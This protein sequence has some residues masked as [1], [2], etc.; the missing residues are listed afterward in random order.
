MLVEPNDGAYQQQQQYFLF[1]N[2]WQTADWTLEFLLIRSREEE[3]GKCAA[4]IFVVM[5]WN[6]A[7]ICW[8]LTDWWSI[9]VVS[10]YENGTHITTS[11][12][13]CTL[14]PHCLFFSFCPAAFFGDSLKWII[15]YQKNK[16]NK[17][18]KSKNII[19]KEEQE[20]FGGDCSVC[21]TLPLILIRLSMQLDLIT[22]SECVWHFD[23]VTTIPCN[24]S[25]ASGNCHSKNVRG[26][27]A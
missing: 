12:G 26:T 20:M 4:N 21:R 24:F 14:L 6:S 15:Q 23:D 18:L 22:S 5:H 9:S 1:Y 13:N 17:Y 11:I 2:F 25:D 27:F 10:S 19:G 16:F 3:E 8:L 7:I